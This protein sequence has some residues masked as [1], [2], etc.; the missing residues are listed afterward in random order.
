[1]QGPLAILTYTEFV[2]IEILGCIFSQSGDFRESCIEYDSR[3]RLMLVAGPS[4]RAHHIREVVLT[5]DLKGSKIESI[6][7]VDLA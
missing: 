3:S 2:T 5:I 1:M 4:P 7:V 6:T